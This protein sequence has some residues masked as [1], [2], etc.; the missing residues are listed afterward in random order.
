MLKG[1]VLVEAV[2]PQYHGKA[3]DEEL[4]TVLPKLG[5]VNCGTKK[6]KTVLGK[7]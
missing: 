3:Y 5:V 1:H 2:R 7:T 6:L 4:G